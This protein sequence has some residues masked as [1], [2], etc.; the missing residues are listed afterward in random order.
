MNTDIL[1]KTCNAHICLAVRGIRFLYNVGHL[2]PYYTASCPRRQQSTVL[3][4][5]I[6]VRVN[7]NLLNRFFS[8][9]NEFSIKLCDT[10]VVI[11][12]V[13][14]CTRYRNHIVLHVLFDSC[15]TSFTWVINLCDF[16]CF[17][18]FLCAHIIYFIYSMVFIV[19][20]IYKGTKYVC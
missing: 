11:I 18:P 10:V 15:T 6:I 7:V 2:L 12:F 1:R 16:S 9:I 17:V 14:L 5:C 3:S 19:K 13:Y 4:H 20:V 8:A